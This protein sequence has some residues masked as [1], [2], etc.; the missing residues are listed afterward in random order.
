MKLINNSPRNYIAFDTILE[1]GKVLDIKDSKTV[2]ILK[3]QPGVEEYIDLDEVKKIKEE[4]EKLKEAKA[5]A[6]ADMKL[7]AKL[8]KEIEKQAKKEK[9]DFAEGDLDREVEEAFLKAKAEEK[10]KKI[11]E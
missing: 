9:R 4:N 6:E 5:K 1:A 10:D 8:R 3:T 2:N 7:K 11:G